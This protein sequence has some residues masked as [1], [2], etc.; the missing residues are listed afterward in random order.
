M[1]SIA[2]PICHR[3]KFYSRFIIVRFN[4]KNNSNDERQERQAPTSLCHC[5]IIPFYLWQLFLCPQF[6]QYACCQTSPLV[7]GENPEQLH[8]TEP[9]QRF[10]CTVIWVA[11]A[12]WLCTQETSLWEF[13]KTI[14]DVAI[15]S[16]IENINIFFIVLYPCTCRA[17]LLKIIIYVLFSDRLWK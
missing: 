1:T 9:V 7:M 12:S 13:A 6:L 16:I 14:T 4:M 2:L 11:K 15:A 17:Q 3:M 10:P 8:P 5:L